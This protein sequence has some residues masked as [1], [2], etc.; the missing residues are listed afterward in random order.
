M[1]KKKTDAMKNVNLDKVLKALGSSVKDE[2]DA[3]DE[4]DLRRQIVAAEASIRETEAE[5]ADDEK[6]QGAK[7]I[8]KD[9]QKG[10]TEVKKAQKAKVKYALHLLDEKGVL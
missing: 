10:Y 5:L 7:E 8:V 9:L 2:M 4:T 6:L 3:M 1:G